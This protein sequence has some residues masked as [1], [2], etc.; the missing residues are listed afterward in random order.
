MTTSARSW[1]N[2]ML[3]LFVLLIFTACNSEDLQASEKVVGS[4]QGKKTITI[5][6]TAENIQDA[7]LRPTSVVMSGEVTVLDVL[8]EAARLQ[9]INV[10]YSGQ[11]F[12]AYIKG[13]GGLQEY[14]HGAKSGWQFRVN[15]KLAE[16][17]AGSY[18][19]QSADEIEWFYAV[20]FTDALE[21]KK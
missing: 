15:G 9:Q 17:G 3:V 13:I 16:E 2:M 18:V 5:S 1:L 19:V 12:S 14:D 11:G 10:D 6:I 8:L 20:D 7:L 4:D 21:E